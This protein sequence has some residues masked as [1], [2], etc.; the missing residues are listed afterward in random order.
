MLLTGFNQSIAIRPLAAASVRDIS[1]SA[2]SSS[3]GGLSPK[4]ND[5]PEHLGFMTP[6][7]LSVLGSLVR[8]AYTLKV[9]RSTPIMTE[10]DGYTPRHPFRI[11]LLS[12]FPK[13]VLSLSKDGMPHLLRF[14][15]ETERFGKRQRQDYLINL[16]L[17]VSAPKQ[18][19]ARIILGSHN[20]TP[21]VTPFSP[22]EID[23]YIDGLDQLVKDACLRLIYFEDPLTP[24]NYAGE[25]HDHLL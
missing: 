13:I 20:Q 6:R 12:D 21:L 24:A 1:F 4:G 16:D 18:R 5:K 14:T 10:K 2:T 17:G 15:R 23:T 25:D 3:A 8:R 7:H 19:Q 22:T 9:S 11:K